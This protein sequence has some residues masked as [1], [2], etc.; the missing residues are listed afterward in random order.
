LVR[1]LRTAQS[2]VIRVRSTPDSPS[3]TAP[4]DEALEVFSAAREL[5]LSAAASVD[6]PRAVLAPRKP[7]RA[8][9]FV[10]SVRLSTEPGSFVVA[11]EAPVASAPARASVAA[12]AGESQDT[13]FADPRPPFAR[14]VTEL[15]VRS[16]DQS[17]RAAAEVAAGADLTVFDGAVPDGVSAN[18][19]EALVH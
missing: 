14:L 4:I 10:R 12:K 6:A 7:D 1:D 11:L 13:L 16:V 3:G 5:L 18:L 9:E 17:L 19:L 2:D 15:L 8:V